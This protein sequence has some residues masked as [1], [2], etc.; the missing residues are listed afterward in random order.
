MGKDS[1]AKSAD[2]SIE[3]EGIITSEFFLR[4]PKVV[5]VIGFLFVWVDIIIS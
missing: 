2:S 1:L 4:L 5:S 3:K